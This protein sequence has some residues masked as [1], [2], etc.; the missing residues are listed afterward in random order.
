MISLSL[1]STPTEARK[2]FRDDEMRSGTPGPDVVRV[3]MPSL[4]R[5]WGRFRLLLSIVMLM[6]LGIIT[7]RAAASGVTMKETIAQESKDIARVNEAELTLGPR[8]A[9]APDP[10]LVE[11]A[12]LLARRA[13]REWYE[14]IV[15]ERRPKR[16]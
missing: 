15:E 6:L 3:R 2:F 5:A 12:R 1:A 13:A 7:V 11:F 16:S 8:S 14:Q 10:R 4:S 9:R